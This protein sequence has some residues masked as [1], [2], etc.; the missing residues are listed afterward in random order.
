MTW[1]SRTLREVCEAPKASCENPRL[2]QQYLHAG[3]LYLTL[4]SHSERPE[5]F[6]MV[7]GFHCSKEG[8]RSHRN[9]A[10]LQICS[11]HKAE[12]R[13]LGKRK[14]GIYA[15]TVLEFSSWLLLLFHMEMTAGS[16]GNSWNI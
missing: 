15:G 5:M 1:K 7:V 16:F 14:R 3:L 9:T 4:M 2:S 8:K 10:Y 6:Y 11:Q 13:A 12:P